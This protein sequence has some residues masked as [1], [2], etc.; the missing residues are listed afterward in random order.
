MLIKIYD[1]HIEICKISDF[2]FKY[3]DKKLKFLIIHVDVI[4]E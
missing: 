2:Q 3:Y 1:F 4:D